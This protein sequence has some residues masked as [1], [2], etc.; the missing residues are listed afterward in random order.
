MDLQVRN[1]QRGACGIVDSDMAVI[2]GKVVSGYWSA[3]SGT[4]FGE[5]ANSSELTNDHC[6][7]TT[8]HYVSQ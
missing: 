8:L 4:E 7:L 1:L 5:R 2:L 3:I 6:S